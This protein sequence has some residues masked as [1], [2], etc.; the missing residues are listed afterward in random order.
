MVHFKELSNY[1]D[2]ERS[3]GPNKADRCKI[4]VN[5]YASQQKH[6][7]KLGVDMT[8]T[9]AIEIDLADLLH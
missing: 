5:Q 4:I 6:L 8:K 7:R 2:E 1:F 9:E 3:L